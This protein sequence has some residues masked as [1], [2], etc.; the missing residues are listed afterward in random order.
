MKRMT[1]ACVCTLLLACVPAA[2]GAC[3]AGWTHIVDNLVRADGS[4]PLG[5]IAVR[6]PSAPAGPVVA[7][8]VTVTIG[9]AGLVDFCLAGGPGW[10]Y[11]ATFALVG[12]AGKP[13]GQFTERWIVPATTAVLTRAQLWG[14]SSAPEFLVSPNQL[15]PAGYTAG[16]VPMWDGTAWMP[17]GGSTTLYRCTVA[18][19]LRVGQTTTVSADCGTAV[20]T[21]L[22]V[23]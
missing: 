7:S 5:T 10:K 15:N 16:Q 3:P 11:D 23:N 13:T 14:G 22:R 8:T 1:A 4:A 19:A 9:A 2:T 20:D 12:A 18:G 6:G 21:G 17:G